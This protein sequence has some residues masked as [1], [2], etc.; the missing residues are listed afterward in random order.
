MNS[1]R[2]GRA[3]SSRTSVRLWRGFFSG[4]EYLQAG[5]LQGE[6]DTAVL[7]YLG[8]KSLV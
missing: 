8:A 2:V 6:A 7:A 4:G 1:L 5:C 3:G